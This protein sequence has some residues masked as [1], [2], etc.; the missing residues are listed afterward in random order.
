MLVKIPPFC[1]GIFWP[2]TPAIRPALEMLV[3]RH[4]HKAKAGQLFLT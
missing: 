4:F 2:Y 1:G 3:F